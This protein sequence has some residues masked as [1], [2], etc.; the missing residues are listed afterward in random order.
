MVSGSCLQILTAE[1]MQLWAG[2][3]GFMVRMVV[4]TASGQ[5]IAA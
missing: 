2:L 4:A 1:V 5:E 3:Y